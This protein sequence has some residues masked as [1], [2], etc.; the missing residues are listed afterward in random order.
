M[1]WSTLFATGMGACTG[2]V[3]AFFLNI[4]ILQRKEKKINKLSLEKTKYIIDKKSK[5]NKQLEDHINK[6]KNLNGS[7]FKWEKITEY[8]LFSPP[9]INFNSLVFLITHSE[10]SEE[11][12]NTISL[13]DAEHKDIIN[14]LKAR[15][16]YYIIYLQKTE[17]RDRI[18]K[19]KLEAIMGKMLFNK[20]T[21]YTEHLI[22]INKNILTDCR[23]A[24]EKIEAFLKNY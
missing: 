7:F 14:T 11:V 3:T 23:I 4:F 16:S 19:D 8:N 9:D 10:K 24:K 5:F 18:D 6:D 13:V 12:I 17:D 15:N 1:F 22:E 21:T 20:L 2:S